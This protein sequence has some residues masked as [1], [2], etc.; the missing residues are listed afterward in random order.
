[1]PESDTVDAKETLGEQAKVLRA[2]RNVAAF[3]GA[4]ISTDSGIPDYRDADGNWKRRTPVMFR[5]FVEKIAARRHTRHWSRLKR[6]GDT[7]PA[8]ATELS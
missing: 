1:M 3:S 4:G 6:A 2:R 7:V 5:N 8:L